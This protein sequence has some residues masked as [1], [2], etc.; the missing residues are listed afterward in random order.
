MMNFFSLGLLVISLILS[1]CI[2]FPAAKDPTRYYALSSMGC[3]EGEVIQRFVGIKSIEVPGYL[4][5]DELIKHGDC[6]EVTVETYHR[7][8]EPFGKMV[9]RVFFEDLSYSCKNNYSVILSPYTR[10]CDREVRLKIIDFYVNEGDLKV[11]FSAQYEIIGGDNSGVYRI[12]LN[13]SLNSMSYSGIVSVMSDIL[14]KAAT[15]VAKRF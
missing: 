10:Q 5:R 1:G 4:K 14:A 7:W 13:E 9:S 11:Y 6:H 3:V 12:C 2:S 15:E 8:V